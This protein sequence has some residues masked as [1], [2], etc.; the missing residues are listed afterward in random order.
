MTLDSGLDV[1]SLDVE[2]EDE[3]MGKLSPG[4][5]VL[6][7]RVDLLRERGR[8]ECALRSCSQ[9]NL[10]RDRERSRIDDCE[11]LIVSHLR[12]A[13]VYIRRRRPSHRP[14]L[15]TLLLGTRLSILY[16]FRELR[17]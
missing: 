4:H 16:V 6:P 10:A 5:V 15:T 12:R 3:M 1:A 13:G 14:T 11:Y 2:A 8:V 9:R 7:E 17:L